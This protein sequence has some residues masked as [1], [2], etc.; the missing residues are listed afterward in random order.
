MIEW[1]VFLAV[2]FIAIIL[3]GAYRIVVARMQN[4]QGPP[5]LQTFYD[6]DKLWGKKPFALQA[7]P[8][9]R[10]APLLYF[11][12]TYAMF[13]FVPIGLVGF[14]YD[15][16]FL[17]YLTILGSAFY[18]LA[19]VSSDSPYSIVASMRE[20]ILM[21][22]YEITLALGIFTMIIASGATAFSG[23]VGN[24]V[25]V[26]PFAGLALIV[27]VLTETHTT[28]FDTASAETEVLAGAETEYPGKGLFFVEL[29]RALIKLFYAVL[30]PFMFFGG[31]IV[32][33]VVGVPVVYFLLAYSKVTTP[34]Y[35]VDQAWWVLFVVLLVAMAE[36]VRVSLGVFV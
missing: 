33:I 34:R 4:R 26:A 5:L 10:A 18:V 17:I 35:R 14:N 30:L 28:P 11:I 24:P 3:D 32:A 13:L 15:F 31:N 19:G 25:L 23:L 27:V 29:T 6:L 22:C 12:A 1:L 21:V 16:I 36:F 9:F 8:F 7:D 2:P 20:M